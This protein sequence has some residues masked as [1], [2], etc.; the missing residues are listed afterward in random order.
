MKLHLPKLL[1]VAVLS[2]TMAQASITN[3]GNDVTYTDETVDSGTLTAV[4]RLNIQGESK[5]TN[6]TVTAGWIATSN[7]ASI[8]PDWNLINKTPTLENTNLVAI[9][10]DASFGVCV[11]IASTDINGGSI[12]V[13]EYTGSDCDNAQTGQHSILIQMG[14]QVSIDR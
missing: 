7:T 4:G 2:C 13:G 9:G 11:N 5:V 12:T 1:L 3:S 8:D 6:S 14:S 10:G